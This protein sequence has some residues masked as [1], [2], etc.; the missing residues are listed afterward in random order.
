MF[1]E[2]HVNIY[3][4][5][6]SL[7]TV[8]AR[9]QVIQTLLAGSEYVTSAKRAGIYS[10]LLSYI[11]RVKEGEMP[12]ALPW[13]APAPAPAQQQQQQQQYQQPQLQQPQYQQP[14]LQQPQSPLMLTGQRQAQAQGQ[15]TN[16]QQK[17]SPAHIVLRGDSDQGF[18]AHNYFQSCLMVLG[19]EEEVALTEESLRTAYKRAAVKAHPDKRGG[20]E[21]AFEAVSRA[22]AYLGDILLRIQGGR[23]KA[24]KVEAPSIL[25]ESRKTDSK[26][27]EQAEPVK[28]NPQ[29]LDLNLFNQ[30]F[31]KNH[32]PD[33]EA[34]GYGD[35]LKS[36]EKKQ[37][38]TF[39]GKFNRDV[40]NNMFEEESRRN[41]AA[42]AGGALAVLTPDALT[43]APS[44]GVEIGRQYT[45]DYTAAANSSMKYTDLKKA[46]TTDNT[47]SQQVAGV[48]VESRNFEAFSSSRKKTP[49]PL[50]NVEMER[51]AEAE[52]HTARM[53]AQ[54]QL[55]AA[56]EGQMA[57]QHFE[58][59][60]RL[61]ITDKGGAAAANN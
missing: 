39:G 27:W 18:K 8:Q 54:R 51:L 44:M 10:H 2:A 48:N 31:E 23:K 15:L 7:R 58:R 11:A 53:E 42:G 59:M 60:K 28:L 49:D 19:L 32:L 56:Q 3:K 9:M 14:Q 41:A 57:T 52:R 43:M 4:K 33:P 21:E 45:G 47:F 29:K 37:G 6:L 22:F 5:L 40:F 16:Y 13:E 38:P 17:V 30:M 34:E 26:D 36:A 12:G 1:P 35:W 46:Y 61:I 50:T 25:T 55:R 24:G 20:S